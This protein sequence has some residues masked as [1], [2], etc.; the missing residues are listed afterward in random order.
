MWMCDVSGVEPWST[1]RELVGSLSCFFWVVMFS[2]VGEFT[3][4]WGLYVCTHD[5]DYIAVCSVHGR[6]LIRNR[7]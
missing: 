6:I 7:A 1:G 5:V 4:I 2:L 3:I